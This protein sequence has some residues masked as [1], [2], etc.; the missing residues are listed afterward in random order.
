[1]RKA[2]K[3]PANNAAWTTNQLRL[4]SKGDH[5]YE[6]EYRIH[7]FSPLLFAFAVNNLHS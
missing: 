5:T 2:L 3:K 4:T 1:M 7:L 6:N